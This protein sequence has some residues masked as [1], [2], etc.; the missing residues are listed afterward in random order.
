MWVDLYKNSDYQMTGYAHNAG[1]YAAA[2][3]SMVLQLNQGKLK[4]NW[5]S[6]M[7]VRACRKNIFHITWPS[8]VNYAVN[9][10]VY[11]IP[12]VKYDD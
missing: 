2:S 1:D 6:I 12:L 10:H 3:N 11:C 5:L 4:Y 9:I 8:R 7:W